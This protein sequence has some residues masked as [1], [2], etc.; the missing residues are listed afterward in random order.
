M[1][2]RGGDSAVDIEGELA[3][4]QGPRRFDLSSRSAL[5]RLF[6]EE[7]NGNLARSDMTNL[8]RRY[9]D[10]ISVDRDGGSH[11]DSRLG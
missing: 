11:L 5:L 10:M 7:V 8:L 3:D 9:V 6:E 2:S 1:V 4:G